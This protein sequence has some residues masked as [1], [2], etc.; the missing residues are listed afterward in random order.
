[1]T[2]TIQYHFRT[3]VGGFHK[4]DVADYI[5]KSTAGHRA[6]LNEYKSRVAALEA[7]N[8]SLRQQ[9]TLLMASNTLLEEEPEEALPPEAPEN[10]PINELEL[11][12]YRRAEAAERLANQRAKK[13]YESLEE[14]CTDTQ[15][16]FYAAN[17]A[18]QET[19]KAILSQAEALE[20]ACQALSRKLDSSREKLSSMDAMIPD[21]VETLEAEL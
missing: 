12:A 6:E 21:P 11:Q 3:A 19:V 1:M 9:L 16:D 5:A 8:D 10:P 15:G 20:Q 4:G 13:L 2:E 7:E 18:V 14:I 17:E